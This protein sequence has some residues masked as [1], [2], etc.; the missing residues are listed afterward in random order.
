M[1]ILIFV[2]VFALW[3]TIHSV[4]AATRF[5]EW[6]RRRM[7]DR[8]YEGLYRLTYN[9]FSVV[10]FLP[11]LYLAM[12]TLPND[13]LWQVRWPFNLA[14]ILVQVTGVIGLLIS[15]LQTDPLRFAGVGQAWR[16]FQGSPEINPQHPLVTSGMY[17]RIRHP[18]Y[19]FSLMFLWFTPIMTW[20]ILF[21][22][23]AAT[24]YF[25]IGSVH[26]ERRLLSEFGESYHLY[27]QRVPRMLPFKIR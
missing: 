14:F 25:W 27:K 10:T 21:F 9:V 8:V 7:G 23:L 18:L 19:T 2:V 3:A 16:Y 15:L 24:A 6:A 12:V 11:P 13:V 5:K 26:E 17:G 4:T 1:E 22:N 20:Q